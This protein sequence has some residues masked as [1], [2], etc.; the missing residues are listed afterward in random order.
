MSL[1]NDSKLL[2]DG[3]KK[4]KIVRVGLPT[5]AALKVFVEKL[6]KYDKTLSNDSGLIE[7]Y[8]NFL[9]TQYKKL[10]TLEF[11]RDRK[12]MSVLCQ[13]SNKSNLMFIKGAPEY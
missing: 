10:A 3:N 6:G 2:A 7:F 4:D 1:C 13:A 11:T 9:N 12:S 5:E 8:N